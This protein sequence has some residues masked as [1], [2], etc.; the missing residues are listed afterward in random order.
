MN[1]RASA[2]CIVLAAL[3]LTACGANNLTSTTGTYVGNTKGTFTYEGYYD[4]YLGPVYDGYWGTDGVFY[5]RPGPYDRHFTAGS[6]DH[7]KR[8]PGGGNFQQMR[9]T[10]T[11][12]PGVDMPNFPHP[13]K[14]DNTV[15]E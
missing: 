13:L 14:S 1:L 11:P 9:G 10:L 4:G 5:Y 6:P 15:S 2:S 12:M 8:T 3:S 7:F